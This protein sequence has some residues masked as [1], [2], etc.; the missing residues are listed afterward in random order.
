MPRELKNGMGLPIPPHF[1]FSVSRRGVSWVEDIQGVGKEQRKPK[2][3]LKT[4]GNKGMGI[5][6][7][8]LRTEDRKRG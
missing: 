3:G 2:I 6:L 1:A 7:Q 4:W 8:Q 5:T